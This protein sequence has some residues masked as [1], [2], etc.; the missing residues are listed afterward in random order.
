MNIPVSTTMA[1]APRY[2]LV[3]DVY[4]LLLSGKQTGGAFALLHGV[5]SPGFGPP[6]HWHTR[7]DE[8]FY[9]LAGEVTF[10]VDGKEIIGKAGTALHV[11]R[12]VKHHFKNCTGVRAEMLVEVSPGGAFDEYVQ[13]VGEPL[14][15]HASVP[16]VPT[17]PSPEHI[18]KV[19]ENGPRF[20]IHFDMKQ[21]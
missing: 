3:G 19:L 11:P 1:T 9:V 10:W 17:P 8:T 6:P 15:A 12:N 21:G 13:A 16:A 14:A 4:T 18:T 20:G 2:L 7:E 5:V